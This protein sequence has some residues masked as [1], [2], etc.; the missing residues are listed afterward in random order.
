[1]KMSLQEFYDLLDQHD[2]FYPMS[3]DSRV[4]EK[5]QANE[6][7]LISLATTITGG[8]SLYV[9][10]LAYINS[11]IEGTKIEKPRRPE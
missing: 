2:W 6:R 3:D 5:G 10:Y 9:S 1:M 11:R 8:K 7:R 4:F